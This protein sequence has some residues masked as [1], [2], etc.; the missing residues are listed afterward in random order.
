MTRTLVDENHNSSV[1]SI[2]GTA[3]ETGWL[4]W[5]P[6][7]GLFAILAAAACQFGV[8]IATPT[9]APT[10]RADALPN[11]YNVTCTPNGNN[12]VC[13]ISG[14]PRVKGDEAGDVVH[15]MFN[16]GD[17]QELSKACNNTATTTL[18]NVPSGGMTLSVQ[19]CRKHFPGTDDCGA[20]SDYKYTPPAAPAAANNSAPAA[21]QKPVLC[22]GGPDAGQTLPPGSSCPA[23]PVAAPAPPPTNAVTLNFQ[24]DGFQI[25]AIITNNSAVSGQC[26]Y[27][28]V[29]T[30][31]IIPERTDSFPI[32]ANATVTRTYP[33]PPPLAQFHATVTCTGDFNGTSDEFGNASADVIG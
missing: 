18:S 23:A 33:A 13:D 4:T 5:G 12:A 25:N 2:S 9:T 21:D 20:W 27:D 29:N 28:A 17:Q 14:C 22:T 7:P 24:K 3:P 10:A 11:G 15:T 6:V 19:G 32:G 8:V 16:D 26:Q 31:G 30:N 1:S